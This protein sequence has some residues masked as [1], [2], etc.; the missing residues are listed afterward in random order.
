MSTEKIC[1]T[2]GQL[3]GGSAFSRV[4]P[5]SNYSP[6]MDVCRAC[7]K[8]GVKVAKAKRYASG[9]L[10][11]NA[12]FTEDRLMSVNEKNFLLGVSA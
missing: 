2:C 9:K 8:H 6:T 10:K 3:K 5:K 11:N 4:D 12:G 1:D 7:I